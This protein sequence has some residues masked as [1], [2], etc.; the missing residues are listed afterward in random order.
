MAMGTRRRR[1]SRGRSWPLREARLVET[2]ADLGAPRP[3]VIYK[4]LGNI[5]SRTVDLA[6]HWN[7]RRSWWSDPWQGGDEHVYLRFNS[8]PSEVRSE[9]ERALLSDAVPALADWLKRA[10]TA[11]EGWRILKHDR[12]WTWADGQVRASGDDPP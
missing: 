10:S 2:L 3:S 11:P 12:T 9:V 6:V 1:L 5:K 8:A 4:S 7:P